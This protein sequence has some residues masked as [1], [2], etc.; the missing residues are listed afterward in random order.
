MKIIE[1]MKSI[2]RP[3]Y[4]LPSDFCRNAEYDV[5]L[6]FE[7]FGRFPTI[8]N[9]RNGRQYIYFEDMDEQKMS[10]VRKMGLNPRRHKSR[11]YIPGKIIYRVPVTFSLSKPAMEVV[12]KIKM[13]DRLY[14]YSFLK[15]VVNMLDEPSYLKYALVYKSESQQITK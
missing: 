10:I 8:V 9:A 5:V 12:A 7:T 6:L 11:R 13:S 15:H 1:R 3:S 4:E 14:F 2:F